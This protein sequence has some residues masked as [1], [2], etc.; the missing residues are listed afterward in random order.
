MLLLVS[1]LMMVGTAATVRP[2][3][4]KLAPSVPPPI[5]RQAIHEREADFVPVNLS[6]VHVQARRLGFVLCPKLDK[7]EARGLIDGAVH[8]QL[9]SRHPAV[10]REDL[11]QVPRVD[12]PRQVI[13][14]ERA[15]SEVLPVVHDRGGGL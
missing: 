9:H 7:G 10:V 15:R 6:P 4:L 3:R 8:C 14:A 12:G 1:V 2:S 11:L 13:D 5:R